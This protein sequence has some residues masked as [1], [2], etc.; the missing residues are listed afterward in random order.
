MAKTQLVFL[1]RFIGGIRQI[2]KCCNGE[3]VKMT[4]LFQAIPASAHAL[5]LR[6]MFCS[7]GLLQE[8]LVLLFQ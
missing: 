4:E 8:G 5:S 7:L 3:L 2:S 1:N 6:F